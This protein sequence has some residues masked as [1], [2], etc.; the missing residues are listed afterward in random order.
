MKREKGIFMEKAQRKIDSEI[1]PLYIVASAK[2][3][4]GISFGKEIGVSREKENSPVSPMLD[5]A[6]KQIEEY[7]AGKR[8][9]FDLPLEFEGTDF[10]KKVWK[11]LCKI[12]YGKTCSYKDIATAV[13]DP[14]ACR[15]VGTANGRNP[16]CVIVP[17]HRVINAGGKLGGYTGGLWIK[18]KLLSLEKNGK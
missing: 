3:V 14:K 13:G 4:Y 10:Q 18:E 17:C 8:R 2:Y 11:E 5:K 16:I 15:A 1:G 6:Q 12:P 7:F 9:V